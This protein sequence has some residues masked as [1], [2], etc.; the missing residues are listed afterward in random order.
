[1]KVSMKWGLKL[2]IGLIVAVPALIALCSLCVDCH[3]CDGVVGAALPRSIH[4][5][6]GSIDAQAKL[7]EVKN[8]VLALVD[9]LEPVAFR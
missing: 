9:V 3:I 8:A 2:V 4:G 1:M 5:I 6:C 7:N